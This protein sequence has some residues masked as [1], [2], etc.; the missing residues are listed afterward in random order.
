MRP[1]HNVHELQEMERL[2]RLGTPT[3]YLARASG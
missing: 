2:H 3:R 1:P